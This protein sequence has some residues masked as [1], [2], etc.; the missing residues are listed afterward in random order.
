MCTGKRLGEEVERQ[1]HDVHVA[2]ALTVAK[3]RSLHAVGARQHTEFGGRDPRAAVVVRVQRQDHAVATVHV[4]Q[5]PLNR[6]GVQIGR[7]HLDGGGQIENQRS[8]GR[9][10]DYF[11][12]RITDLER[13]LQL[14]ARETL[15][16]VFVEEGRLGRRVFE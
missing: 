9:R 15:R 13:V 12:H 5:E 4:A 7:I 10:I 2:G 11:D 6:V 16:R 8:L 1:V 3:E 14:G